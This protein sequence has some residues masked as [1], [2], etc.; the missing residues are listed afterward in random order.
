M[1]VSVAMTTYN[2]EKY[3]FKQLLSIYE[4]T[5]KTSEVIICDDGSTDNT[6]NI[7]KKFIKERGLG[8]KWKIII[9]PSNKGYVKNFIDCA[10]MS[11]GEIIFF[12]DQDDIWKPEKIEIMLQEFKKNKTIQ[13]LTCNYEWIDSNG[14]KLNFFIHKMKC[15]NSK[16]CKISFE[17]HIKSCNCTGM[18][19]A[20][21]RIS[22]NRIFP[23]IL[24]YKLPFDT[25]IGGL[26]SI[27]GGFYTLNKV[28]VLRRLHI[29]NTSQ[30]KITIKSRIKSTKIQIDGLKMRIN[31]FKK[32]LEIASNSMTEKDKFN[33]HQAITYL[34]ESIENINSRRISKLFFSLFTSNSMINRSYAIGNLICAIFG[35]SKSEDIVN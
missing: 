5:K 7:I 20:I 26:T 22:F 16:L 8:E 28:L 23:E 27:N 2:G 9:N 14:K 33:L 4:Q 12:C 15:L 11:T 19:L 13:A 18:T 21:K 10:N 30:P 31:L 25:S 6:V 35:K 32:Y 1:T 17:E 29:N 3:I 24:E 34:E